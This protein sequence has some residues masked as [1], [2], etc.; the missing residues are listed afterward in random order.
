MS[1]R[2]SAKVGE[3]QDKQTQGGFNQNQ[4]QQQG[5]FNQNQQQR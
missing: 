3:Y 5:G 2:L 1:R 4:G